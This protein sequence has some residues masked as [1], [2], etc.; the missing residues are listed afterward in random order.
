VHRGGW[1]CGHQLVPVAAEAVPADVRAKIENIRDVNKQI[2]LLHKID[3]KPQ[4]G[5]LYSDITGGVATKIIELAK[6]QI[7]NREKTAI[8]RDIVSNPEFNRIEKNTSS[9]TAIYKFSTVSEESTEYKDNL[10]GARALAKNG[11]DAYMLPNPRTA[12]SADFIIVKKEKIYYAEMKT[13]Y[14]KNSIDNRLSSG[15]AQSD[16]IILNIVGNVTPR[17]AGD[18]IRDFYL[19]NPQTKEIKVLLGGKMINIDYGQLKDPKFL[20][21]FMSKWAK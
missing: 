13:I 21:K 17:N 9:Q 15:A 5:A 20:K 12:A 6:K 16:R 18:A 10:N 19:K 11:Y 14:G 4:S 1:N 3:S 2:D 8:L 7:S